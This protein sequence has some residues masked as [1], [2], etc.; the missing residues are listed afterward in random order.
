[1]I[2]LFIRLEPIDKALVIGF[3]LFAIYT[4]CAIYYVQRE[5]WYNDFSRAIE[6]FIANLQATTRSIEKENYDSEWMD[7]KKVLRKNR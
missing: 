4:I 2:E 3:I 5:I 1:M 7:E 6:S